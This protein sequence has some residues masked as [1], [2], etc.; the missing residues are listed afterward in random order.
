[1][2]DT[3][4]QIVVLD[5]ELLEAVQQLIDHSGTILDVCTYIFAALLFVIGVMAA[6]F[7]CILLYKA[8]KILI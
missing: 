8:V 4:E 6:V 2:S 3:I 5:P 1:M 7:V